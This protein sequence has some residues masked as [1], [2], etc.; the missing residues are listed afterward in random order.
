[1]SQ[2]RD[3]DPHDDGDLFRKLVGDVAPLDGPSRVPRPVAPRPKP[4][5]ARPPS[6][7][8][9]VVEDLRGH[10]HGV[11]LSQRADLAAGRVPMGMKIDLHGFRTDG[12]Q[13]LLRRRIPEAVAAGVRCVLIVH[14]RGRHS[15]GA[16]VLREAVV[17]ALTTAPTVDLVRAFCPARPA[18]GG[19]GAM[20]VLL[21]RSASPRSGKPG[22]SDPGSAEPG[23][24]PR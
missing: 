6:P 1:M 21:A 3:D 4:R 2:Q 10:A 8:R 9:F 20:Y 22:G 17:K 14:G 18:D 12:A 11:S 15:D 24:D 5:V 16:P 19:P 23:R 7:P 13:D